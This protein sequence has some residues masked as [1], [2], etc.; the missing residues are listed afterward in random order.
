MF[1]RLVNG[2]TF[3]LVGS[4]DPD[5]LVGSPPVGITFSEFALS[6]PASWAYLAPILAQNGG[7]ASFI[8]TPRGR[9]NHAFR[10]LQMA[11]DNPWSPGN[12]DGWFSEVLTVED[13]DFPL[14]LVE[15]QRREYHGLYGIDAGDA[16]V[17]QE[18]FCS[19]EA[20]VLGAYL[21]KALARAER[22]GRLVP[23]MADPA[24]PLNSSWDLGKGANMFVWLYQVSGNELRVLAGISGAHDEVIEDVVEKLE[25]WKGAHAPLC[26]W[27][28]DYVPHDARVRELGS[29][30]T[31]V[32]TFIKLGRKPHLVPHHKIDDGIAA[33][34]LAIPQAWFDSM[35]C[36]EGLEALRLYRA[37]YDEDLKVFR[38]TPLHDW[39]SHAADAFRYLAMAWR[40]VRAD[41]PVPA[42]RRDLPELTLNDLWK[43]NDRPERGIRV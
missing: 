20:A 13:T 25:K 14:N 18:Y 33:A 24:L 9:G 39:T 37:D 40:H 3:K 2:S 31:R 30:K 23:L 35:H 6:N 8:T 16:L 28:L 7:W 21:A 19:F 12:P 1:I 17:E 41:P 10:M 22:A 32:E 29:G 27:G 26:R 42:K 4:D 15:T 11:R 5:S 36:A 43:L 38:D 34:R